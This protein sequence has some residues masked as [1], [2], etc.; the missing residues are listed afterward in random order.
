MND[1]SQQAGISVAFIKYCQ[2]IGLWNKN[3]IM[4]ESNVLD[5]FE[6]L[7]TFQCEVVSAEKWHRG[8][9]LI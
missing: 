7:H 9:E 3:G 8:K 6:S 2:H 4:V 5:L 1:W